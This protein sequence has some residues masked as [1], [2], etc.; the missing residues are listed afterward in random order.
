M[1][2]IQKP[3]CPPHL[4]DDRWLVLHPRGPFL[5]LRKW[6]S[7]PMAKNAIPLE[8]DQQEE[9]E[10]QELEQPKLVVD[11]SWRF[12]PLWIISHFLALAICALWLL[13]KHWALHN[14]LAIAFCIQVSM[15]LMLASLFPC[16]RSCRCFTSPF[17]CPCL[18]LS[19][20]CTAC[21]SLLV[22]Q[23]NSK[24]PMWFLQCPLQ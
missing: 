23:L 1:P 4:V 22:V 16:L 11:W 10:Q 20:R 2:V 19:S 6:I 9:E 12:S 7:L 13:T 21:F 15:Q 14:L 5:W 3:L 8:Q 18:W 17:S 24:C